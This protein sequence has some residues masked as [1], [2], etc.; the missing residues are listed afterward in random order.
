[1]HNLGKDVADSEAYGH[2]LNN[3][4]GVD[5]EFWEKNENER[6]KSVIDTCQKNGIHTK[7]KAEDI[8]SANT[9][10]NTLLC[11]DIFNEKHGL[12]LKEVKP[13]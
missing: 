9:R 11:A 12:E 10:L 13:I 3:L 5:K 2:V 1:M 6:A 8:V 7:V 4:Y